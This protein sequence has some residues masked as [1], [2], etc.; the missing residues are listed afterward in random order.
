VAW[1]QQTLEYDM[2]R[3]YRATIPAEEQAEIWEEVS[4]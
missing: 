4:A 1:N 3:D 2:M